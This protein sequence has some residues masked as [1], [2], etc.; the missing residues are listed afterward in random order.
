MDAT[1]AFELTKHFSVITSGI[2]GEEEARSA[3]VGVDC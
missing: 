1:K 3:A 2:G